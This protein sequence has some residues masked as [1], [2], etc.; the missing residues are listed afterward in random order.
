M[1]KVTPNKFIPLFNRSVIRMGETPS[2]NA[3][4]SARGLA[5]IGA[6]VLNGGSLD[7]ESIMRAETC[8]ALHADLVAKVDYGMTGM[9]TE[10]SQGGI[11]LYR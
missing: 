11:N 8:D 6:C 10:F 7:G 2:G 4:C 3:C 5:K 9:V 1:D